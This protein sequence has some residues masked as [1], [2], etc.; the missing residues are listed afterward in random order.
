MATRQLIIERLSSHHD[1]SEF[2]CGVGELNVYLQKYASQHQRKGVGRTYVAT[3][4]D[5]ERVLGYYTI[6]AGAVDFDTVP[7]NL[8]RHPIPVVLIGRLAV[9]IGARG[10]GL[11]ETLLIHA[12]GSAQRVAEIAGVYAVVVDALDKQAKSFYL[13]YGFK[14]LADDHL[15]LYLPVR[16]INKLKL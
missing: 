5:P 16:T 8:P 3:E 6:S 9:D 2:D 1:R 12:L 4:D 7:E 11:G 10:R 14:E 13:K 15:H